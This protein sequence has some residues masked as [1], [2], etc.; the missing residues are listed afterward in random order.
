MVSPYT[1]RRAP[2]LRARYVAHECRGLCGRCR[3][4]RL[5]DG[6]LGE[7]ERRTYSADELLDEWVLLRD[8][9]HRWRDA[10]ARLGVTEAALHKALHVACRRGDPR[11]RRRPFARSAAA[12]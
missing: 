7:A 4:R 11:G 5:Q 9:G 3:K 6:T 2:E 1:L 8:D 12:V 10:A